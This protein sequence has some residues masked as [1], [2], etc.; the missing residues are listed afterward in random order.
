MG[1]AAFHFP[2]IVAHQELAHNIGVEWSFGN[3]EYGVGT[4]MDRAFDVLDT[5]S[6]VLVTNP[7]GMEVQLMDVQRG[8]YDILG[9]H[10]QQGE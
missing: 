7:A 9:V 3:K 2:I 6:T 10:L 8:V 4:Y 1:D 5:N